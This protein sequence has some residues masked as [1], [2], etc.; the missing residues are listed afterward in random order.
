M[1]DKGRKKHTWHLEA[2]KPP[3]WVALE[4][5]PPVHPPGS[6]ALIPLWPDQTLS[7]ELVTWHHGHVRPAAQEC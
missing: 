5:S 3:R 7:L 2:A 6:P 1:R 4:R